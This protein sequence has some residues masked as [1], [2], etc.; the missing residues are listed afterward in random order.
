[1]IVSRTGSRSLAV[2]AL[3][4]LLAAPPAAPAADDPLPG[5][6]RVVRV[7]DGDTFEAEARIWLGQVVTTSVRLGGVD[8]P[9]LR[10]GCDAKR[11][12]AVRARD[13]LAAMVQEAFVRLYD[14]EKDKYGGRVVARVETMAD[15][16][17][18]A[19][20]VA[21]GLARPYDGGAR[22]SWCDVLAAGG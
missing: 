12:L 16:D 3:A 5:P 19:W 7:I 14:I 10:G 11:A 20:L 18:G 8:A 6:A 21:A 9:E 13:E 15:E 1:M 22:G 4:L 2:L 17:V